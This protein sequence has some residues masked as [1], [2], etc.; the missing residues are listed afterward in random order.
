MHE[1]VSLPYELLDNNDFELAQLDED[2]NKLWY[3]PVLRSQKTLMKDH[4]L[5]QP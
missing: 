3:S 5:K 4:G 1:C 2:D